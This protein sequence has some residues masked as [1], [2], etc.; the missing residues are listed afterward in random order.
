MW[1][2]SSRQSSTLKPARATYEADP[3][4]Y[5]LA[6]GLGAGGVEAILD[7]RAKYPDNSL[8]DLYDPDAMPADLLKAHQQLDKAVDAL[9]GRGSFDETKRLAVLLARYEKLIRALPA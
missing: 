6:R 2:K 8:A 9:F 3:T 7:R 5:G 4:G 1:R